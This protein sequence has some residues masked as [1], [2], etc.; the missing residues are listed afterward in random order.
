[1]G[2]LTHSD[3]KTNFD[4]QLPLEGLIPP[5]PHYFSWV[6]LFWGGVCSQANIWEEGVLELDTKPVTSR[7]QFH[8]PIPGSLGVRG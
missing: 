1:M 7:S 6:F 2:S 4:P 3:H 5:G 8:T